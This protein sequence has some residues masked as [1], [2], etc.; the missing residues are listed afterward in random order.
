MSDLLSSLSMATRAL[1]A[2]RFGL[3]ATG[4][5]IAN[6]NT[7]GYSKRVVDFAEVPPDSSRSAG[8]G[9]DVV[10]VRAMRDQLIERRLRQELP[11]ERREAAV[12]EALSIVEV[13]LGKPGQ[14]IDAAL[15]RYF[16]AFATL[17]ESPASSVARQEVLLQGESVAAAFRDMAGRIAVSQRD[18][19]GQ[20]SSLTA[21]VTDLASQIA[22][23]NE[24]IQRTGESA[25]G[26]LHLQDQ[27]SELVRRLSALIDVDVLQRADGGVDITIG[28]GRALVIGEN[29]YPVTVSQVG[30]VN[31]VFSAGVDITA[32]I[33]GGTLGGVIFTRDVLLPAYMTDLDDL[34]YEFA[35]QVNTLHAAGVGAD[36]GTGRNFFAFVP[37]IGGAAGAAGAISVDATVAADVDLIAA[38][39]AGGPVGDNTT[40][41]NIAEL[42]NARVFG[43]SATLGETWG[44]LVYR[45]GRDAQVA[46]DE[47]RSRLDIVNQVDELRDQVSGIS[48]DEEAMQLM[49]FQR[50][51]EANARFFRAVDMTLDTLM[52]T[53]AR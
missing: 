6:V 2:Q 19:D 4:Q 35:T 29:D 21:A 52:Q 46:K 15:N 48:L 22:T 39:G 32:E 16:D 26:I 3:D 43:G 37:A 14:S 41:R 9:V 44:Q 30:S 47:Q 24:T 40:A 33:S 51:Y 23:I 31:H 53:L 18:T 1:E 17:S 20:V 50:A 42:R 27:Q 12:A 28:N 49:R 10:G 25:G 38:A 45:V 11:A 13:A 36:G 34:A 5:N 8:R 7:P